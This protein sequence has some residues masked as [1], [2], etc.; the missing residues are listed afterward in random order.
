MLLACQAQDKSSD[1]KNL[2]TGAEQTELYIHDLKSKNV[3]V[4]ANQTSVISNSKG[5]YTHLV[6]SLLAL[7]IK[8]K[9]VFAPEHG[10]RGQADAG[11]KVDDAVDTKTGLP[12]ISLYGKHKK[13]TETD[14]TDIDIVVFDI[15]DVG[16]RFYTYISTLHYVMEACAE[17]NI[18]VLVLDRPNPNRH[19]VDGPF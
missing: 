5:N 3:A 1:D 12:I 14:L 8:V 10:F 13:P 11:E 15:Q 9:K 7:N 16:V 17:Q 19:Y 18:P 6:D 4:V 2:L